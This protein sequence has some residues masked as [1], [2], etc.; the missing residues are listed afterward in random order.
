MVKVSSDA[1]RDS[2]SAPSSLPEADASELDPAEPPRE[3]AAATP[4]AR[5]T[6]ITSAPERAAMLSGLPNGSNATTGAESSPL[7]PIAGLATAAV[8]SVMMLG[9]AKA[10]AKSAE[11]AAAGSFSAF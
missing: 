10:A 9:G 8:G 2:S 7:A 1:S 5:E 4:P 3:V 11:T 6:A